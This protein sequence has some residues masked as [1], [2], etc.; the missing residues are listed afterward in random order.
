MRVQVHDEFEKKMKKTIS[1]LKD[2]LNAIRAGRANPSL[3]D[4]ITVDYYG[5]AM[6]LKQIANVSSPEPRLLVIQPYDTTGI[7]DIEKAIM[8]SDIGINPSN[9][10]KVIR[11]AVP[12]LTEERRRDLTKLIKKIGENS[13]IAIRNER[14]SANET[15]KKMQKNSEITEDDFKKAEQTVEEM[16]KVYTEQVD[17]L[18]EYKE[19]EIMEV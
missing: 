15:F 2:E 10:G 7:K 6:P 12:M 4:R 8:Q 16:T 18:I 14:R 17:T 11:L 19:K 1:V 5:S 9:D 13:K 3:L